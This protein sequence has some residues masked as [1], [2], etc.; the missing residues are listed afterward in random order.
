MLT[1]IITILIQWGILTTPADFNQL[2]QTQ[3]DQY[4]QKIIDDK[5]HGF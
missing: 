5:I 2:N 4:I 1:I 3:K